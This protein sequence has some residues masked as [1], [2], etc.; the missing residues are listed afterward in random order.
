MQKTKIVH[1]TE[2][3]FMQSIITIPTPCHEDWNA[4]HPNEL[5]RHCDSCV[6]TVVDFTN[7]QPQAI[8]KHINSNENVCGRFTADQLN[9][10]IPSAENFVKQIAYFKIS[11]LK[12]IAAIFLFAFVIG[13]SSCNENTL[14][15]MVVT[16]GKT[17]MKPVQT[18][19]LGDTTILNPIVEEVMQG[20]V[21]PKDSTKKNIEKIKFTKPTL[22]TLTGDVNIQNVPEAIGKPA[23]ILETEEKKPIC[24]KTKNIKMGE[25]AMLDIP[26]QKDTTTEMIMG[27]MIATPVSK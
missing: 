3:E 4:M 9:E 22:L 8:L 24:P 7:W 15:G 6:K 25:P 12:K 11:T 27:K 17:E 10:P 26:M 20:A 1:L 14:E 19:L 16:K 21:I 5:G 23:L 18:H 13:G 2:N